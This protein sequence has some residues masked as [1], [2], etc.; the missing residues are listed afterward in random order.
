MRKVRVRYGFFGVVKFFIRG[1]FVLG[2]VGWGFSV[3][4]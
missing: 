1:F 3:C 4:F 2:L